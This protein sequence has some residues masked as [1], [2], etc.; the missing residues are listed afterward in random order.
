MYIYR[1]T[2]CKLIRVRFSAFGQV[3]KKRGEGVFSNKAL[4]NL[5]IPLIIE[6]LLAVTIGVADTVMVSSCGEAAVSGISLVDSVNFLLIQIF[7][8]LATGGAVICS[9]YIG[10]S[11]KINANLAAKQLFYAILTVSLVISV[12]TIALRTT[13]LRLI[14]GSIEADVMASAKIY[15]LISAISYPFL[16]IYNAGAALFRAMGDSKTSL[17]ISVL[18]NAINVGGNAI[19]IY[20]LRMGVTGAASATLLSRIV[21]AVL[22]TVL[23][24]NAH[25]TVYYDRLHKFEFKWSIIKSVLQ[26][27]VPNGLENSIFQIGKILVSS[28]VAGFGT[29]SITA[30]AISGNLASIQ[31]IPASA[32]GM[33][34][35]T[36]V[37]QCVGAKDY[38]A[39][40]R[41]TKKLMFL[42]FVAVWIMTGFMIL[43]SDTIL[44]FYALSPETLELTKKVFLVHGICAVV[45]WPPSFALP[46]ALRAAN[47]VRFTMLV[48]LISMWTFRIGFSYVL[49]VY[50]D[51]GVV[52]IWVAMCIDWLCRSIFFIIRFARG[53]WKSI[54]YI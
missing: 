28:I 21:G 18:M 19:G 34:M 11:D 39:V 23:L 48:S 32:I 29:V 8:S 3:K 5:I 35:L 27:G 51:M 33:A 45:I 17:Y 40:K 7:S 26:I 30:N 52:G 20:A 25:R 13:A 9:Q 2:A 49:A 37:G 42:S 50:M 31:I 36:V 16:G 14:F 15:F 53:K 41:Y 43:F 38:D 12:L 10:R 24:T 44:S 54:S 6:Q 46:N 47:D 4:R 1:Y 22:I